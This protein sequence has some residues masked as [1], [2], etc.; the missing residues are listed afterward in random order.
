MIFYKKKQ[1]PEC[2]PRCAQ[3]GN[4]RLPNREQPG[5]DLDL[6]RNIGED[7]LVPL[8]NL[9]GTMCSKNCKNITN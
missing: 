4:G 8:Q 1:I 2:P 3:N 9:C 6:G 5:A 7:S